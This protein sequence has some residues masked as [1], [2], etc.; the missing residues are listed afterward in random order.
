MLKKV[1]KITG[2]KLHYAREVQYPFGS[3]GRPHTFLIEGGFL[4]K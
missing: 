1:T 3:T 4:K 2:I